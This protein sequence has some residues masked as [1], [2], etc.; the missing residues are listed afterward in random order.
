M[1][2]DE[3]S[4]QLSKKMVAKANS[5]EGWKQGKFWDKIKL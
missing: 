2:N 5:S 1:A 4:E 3:D